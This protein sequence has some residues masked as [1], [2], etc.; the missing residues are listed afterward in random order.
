MMLDRN[1]EVS[2][3][4][5]IATYNNTFSQIFLKYL[6]T[7]QNIKTCHIYSINKSIFP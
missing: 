2:I 5:S 1:R 3:P 4:S 7:K 6:L